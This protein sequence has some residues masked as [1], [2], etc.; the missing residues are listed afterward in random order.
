MNGQNTY[1]DTNELYIEFWIMGIEMIYYGVLHSIQGLVYMLQ[2]CPTFP[3]FPCK[4]PISNYAN[5]L[6]NNNNNNN[7]NGKLYSSQISYFGKT[8]SSSPS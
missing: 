1:V 4:T 3:Y 6:N 5:L 8:C 2:V 7:N